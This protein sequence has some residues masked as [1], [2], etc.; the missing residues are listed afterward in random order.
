[1]YKKFS[2]G[3]T[4]IEL[5][6]VIAI[7][8]ILA[9]IVLVSLNGARG[10]GRDAN[11]VATLQQIGRAITIADA[12]PAPGIYSTGTTGCPAKSLL[13]VCTLI[14]GNA[15]GLGSFIDPSAGASGT[16]CPT[17]T[18]AAQGSAACSYSLTGLNTAGT[19]VAAT[20]SGAAGTAVPNTQQWEVCAVLEGGNQS[21]GGTAATYGAV[22]VGSDTGGSIRAGCL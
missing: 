22:H 4:L 19:A 8:G 10:K 15:S 11:R 13:S 6:V 12:D 16:A 5:L 2:K 9:S 7:I 20:V 18:A 21:Y 3:F 14:G 1:M 17:Q